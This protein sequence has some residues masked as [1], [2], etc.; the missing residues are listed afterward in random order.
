MGVEVKAVDGVAVFVGLSVTLGVVDF[1][2]I[3]GFVGFVLG[4][5]EGCSLVVVVQSEPTES[6]L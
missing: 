2:V 4:V 6:G 3:L 1:V 5:V